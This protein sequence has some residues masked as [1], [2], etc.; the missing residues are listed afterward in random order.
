[1][2]KYLSWLGLEVRDCVTGLEGVITSI[3]FDICGCIQ[4]LLTP[5]AIGG[6]RSDSC[7]LDLK[8]LVVIGS[9]VIEPSDFA[10]QE[11]TGAENNK[12]VY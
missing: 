6:T 12:P 5:K 10:L 7:W 4:G 11:D 1:M 8:R 9:F 3:S 2:E